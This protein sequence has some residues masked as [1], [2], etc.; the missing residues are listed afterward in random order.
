MLQQKLTLSHKIGKVENLLDED[1]LSRSTIHFCV[2][3]KP[4]SVSASAVVIGCRDKRFE[5]PSM[6]ESLAR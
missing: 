1:W 5:Q 6:Y 4:F 3:P 2:Y